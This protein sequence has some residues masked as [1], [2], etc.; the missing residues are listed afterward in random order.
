MTLSYLGQKVTE[1]RKSE[2][3]PA[4][5]PAVLADFPAGLAE[6]PAESG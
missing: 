2:E 6:N 4:D 5:F 3:S 1:K